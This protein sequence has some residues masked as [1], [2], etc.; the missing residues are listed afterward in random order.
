MKIENRSRTG[1]SH[2][3]LRGETGETC[4]RGLKEVHLARRFASWVCDVGLQ[5]QDGWRTCGAGEDFVLSAAADFL[6]C[7]RSPPNTT[8]AWIPFLLP[9][10]F[11]SRP[12]LSFLS[13]PTQSFSVSVRQMGQT[14]QLTEAPPP[15]LVE[16]ICHQCSF[17]EHWIL[18]LEYCTLGFRVRKE[19]A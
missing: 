10:S 18:I 6:S 8:C 12:L 15:L 4:Q 11:T 5:R 14:M 19:V 13:D 16:P 1:L 3:P 7:V 2:S 9:H 17:I